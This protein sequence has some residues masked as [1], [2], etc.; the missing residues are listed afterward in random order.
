MD[1]NVYFNFGVANIWHRAVIERAKVVIVEVTTGLPYVYGDQN[2]VHASKVDY[3]I[4]G[5]HLPAAELPNPT[6]TEIDRA[7]ARRIAVRTAGAVSVGAIV[8]VPWR[9]TFQGCP[10]SRASLAN[11]FFS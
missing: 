6:P 4:E 9:T 1:E 2:G 10:F 5:D 7:V 8:A 11:Y 3:I